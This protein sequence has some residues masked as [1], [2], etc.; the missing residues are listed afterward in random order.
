MSRL[1]AHTKPAAHN[2]MSKQPIV[3]HVVVREIMACFQTKNGLV[4]RDTPTHAPYK[5]TSTR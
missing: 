4:H 1:A 5:G 3:R 2:V